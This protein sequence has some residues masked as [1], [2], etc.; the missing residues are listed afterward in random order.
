MLGLHFR[1][2]CCVDHK[3]KPVSYI[4]KYLAANSAMAIRQNFLASHFY[5]HNSLLEHVCTYSIAG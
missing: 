4:Y 2:M 3:W 5:E 1:I